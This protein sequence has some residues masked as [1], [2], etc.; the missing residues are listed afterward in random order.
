MDGLGGFLWDFN[1]SRSLR[2]LGAIG[3]C[4]MPEPFVVA[5]VVRWAIPMAMTMIAVTRLLVRAMVMI[6]VLRLVILQIS[7]DMIISYDVM[8]TYVII[9]S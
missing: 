8:M 4:R 7:Y 9:T 6:L 5:T 1:M 2:T 3:L